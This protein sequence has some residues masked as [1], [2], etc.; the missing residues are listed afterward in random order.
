LRSLVDHAITLFA[1]DRAAVRLR[2]PDGRCEAEVSRNL[3]PTYLASLREVGEASLCGAAL[4]ARRP[5]A[6]VRY[7]DDP[8]AAAHRA[9]V[10]AEGFDTLSAAPLL[11]GDRPLGVLEVFHDRP[12]P[13]PA[14]DL[15][16]LAE[17]AAQG[18]VA[19]GAARDYRRTATWAAQLQSI[20]QLGTRLNS[21]STVSEIGG[22][23]ASELGQLIDYHNVRV[24]RLYGDELVPVALQ[25]RVGEY[26]DETAEQLRLRLG[27]GITGWVALH[28]V[29]QY[30]PDAATD[31]RARTIPGTEEDLPES[32]LLAPMV[33]EDRV[34]GVLVLSKL[35]L[36]QFGEDDL[37][38]LTIYASF[39]AQAMANADAT[40]RL[41]EQSDR[42]ARRLEAQRQLL[43]LTE[44]ILT[45]LDPKAVL[46][47]V[48]EH[49]GSLVA[50]DNISIERYDRTTGELRPLAAR[51]VHAAEFLQPWLPGERGVAHWVVERNEPVLIADERA[52][53][54]V[55][56]FR[57][58]GP[59]AGS[60]IVVP[61]RDRE[62][63]SG[64][65]TLERLGADNRFT[66]EDFELVQLFAAHVSI[67][68]QN[69]EVHRAVEIR[70]QTDNLTGLLNHGTFHEWLQRMV[71]QGER[72]SL[73]M[74]DLDDFKAVND[75][76]GHQAGDR[77]LREIAEAIVRVGRESDRVF[78]YGGDEF[79]I[80]LP[81]TDRRGA[82]EVAERVAAAIGG[83]G[84]PGSA[85]RGVRISGSIGH[86]T[87]P[88]DGSTAE[89]VLLAAD[90]A[91]FV[92]KRSGHGRIA[93]AVEGLALA[94]EFSPQAPTPVD[95][96]T[97]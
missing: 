77:L 5:V 62:G 92:A 23:I 51:G 96:P 87:Y 10:L 33:F 75:T 78:R 60:L 83:V 53:P 68:L 58:G 47:Q 42:L 89:G 93:T 12:R 66:D 11:D 69:A 16:L 56:D 84:G 43:R 34:L 70:A 14:D 73:V 90:R 39:A 55:N 37:R 8:R 72:F 46:D 54:R 15:E 71:G 4:A 27:E 95:E 80:L 28:R 2:G 19:I 44:S 63:P 35:G 94:A 24:Y 65:L 20:Q 36:A 41:R 67:A 30:L 61:L 13:W 85:W 74:V 18:A 48:A 7:A 79:A 3:S 26:V 82:A 81:G 31:P 22:A 25:G 6:A 45:T 29:P 32:M 49:L 57:A 21:L 50:H 1:A 86:A 9:A 52:D 40:E 88:D 17:L 91:C 64:V 97:I 38:L 76:L 59:V